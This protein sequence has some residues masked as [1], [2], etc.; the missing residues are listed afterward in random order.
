MASGADTHTHT[1][2]HTHTYIR[3]EVI[4]RNQ[5]RA[6]LRR[7]APGLTKRADIRIKVLMYNII[8]ASNK[9]T[10]CVNDNKGG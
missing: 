2:T 9:S 1:H 5:A 3:T 7:R 6:G 8:I 10:R 4:L